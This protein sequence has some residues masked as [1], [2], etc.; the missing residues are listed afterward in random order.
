MAVADRIVP[1]IDLERCTGC[2]LCVEYCP[3]AAAKM[4]DERPMITRPQ[5][6]SYCGI[7]EDMCP[8]GAVAL[9]YEI[10]LPSNPQE[11]PRR[12]E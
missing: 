11:T 12:M 4:V 5:A 3:T 7:C 6:C 8:A 2:G 9:V 1:T 10:V